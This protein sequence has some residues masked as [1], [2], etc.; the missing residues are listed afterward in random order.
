MP[1]WLCYEVDLKTRSPKFL[2]INRHLHR[3]Q[4]HLQKL[5]L[6]RSNLFQV[7][8]L[9]LDF[10]NRVNIPISLSIIRRCVMAPR[11]LIYLLRRLLL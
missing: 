1:S 8:V 7:Q 4:L 11:P 10:P 5:S 9:S 2:E 3:A 6:N